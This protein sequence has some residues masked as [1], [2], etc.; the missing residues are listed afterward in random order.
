MLALVAGLS[1]GH[2][3]GLLVVGAVFIGFALSASFLAPRRWPDFPGRHGMSVFILASFVLFFGM[4]AAVY[5]FGKESE[6][7]N[8]AAAQAHVGKPAN[9]TIKVT[10]REFHIQLPPLKELA[11]GT[12]TF[13]VHNVGQA[14]HNLVI[15]GGRA[16]GPQ[17]T[18]LIQPG[19][20]AKLT[21][22]LGHGNYTLYCSVDGHRKLGMQAQIS[23]G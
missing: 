1:T 6:A 13:D 17:S 23:V 4:L 20:D 14:A 22:S 12:Y 11:Q 9:Q 7:E 19:A 10:E 18:P 15:E 2:K 21:V 16:S 8:A 3:I 5:V